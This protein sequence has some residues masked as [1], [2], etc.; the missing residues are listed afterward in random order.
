MCRSL[1]NAARSL[2]TA[3]LLA[4]PALSAADAITLELDAGNSDRV[5]TPVRWQLPPDLDAS[6]DWKL[7]RAED[8][9][10]VAL[11]IDRGK[12][13]AAIWI[14]EER[15]PARTTRRYH[16]E[17]GRSWSFADR[18]TCHDVSPKHLLVRVAARD[19]LTYNYGTIQPPAKVEPV[20][21]RSGYIHPIY[22]PSGELISDDFPLNHKHHHGLWMPWSQTVFEGRPTNFWEQARE[23]GKVECVGV[24]EKI[25]G[26]VFGGFRVRH[27]FTALKA[28][29]GPKPVLDETWEVTVYSPDRY[30][31]VDFT[32][33]E[34]C[35]GASSLTLKE[36][37]Y[38]GFGF[39]GA[40]EWEGEKGVEYLTSEGK[41]RLDGHATRARWCDM[42]GK[43]KGKM[44][45]IAF[46]CHPENFRAPQ[47]MRIHPSEPFFNFAPCQGGDFDLQ[48]GKELVSRYRLY[49]HEGPAD[50]PEL[51]RLWNDYAEPPVVR[52]LEK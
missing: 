33:V 44:V 28:A 49:L 3:A 45:G 9:K 51:E 30:F 11:Q 25:G 2:I 32:S 29:G 6:G 48:P 36:Y 38:G 47:G 34:K 52:R 37:R 31:L 46:F 5:E 13:P 43:V 39:R 4:A 27:R 41:T 14:L 19:V 35:A 26:S 17:I 18:V 22:A 42:Y 20:F 7:T 16:L 10:E 50:R 23:E 24:D 1:Q 15:L 21:A 8:G 40:A 12:S